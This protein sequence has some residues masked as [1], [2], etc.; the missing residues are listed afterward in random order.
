VPNTSPSM[1]LDP[2]QCDAV[3]CEAV[4]LR[5]YNTFAP[6]LPRWRF[7]LPVGWSIGGHVLTII[8]HY[9]TAIED[10]NAVQANGSL[11]VLDGVFTLDAQYGY[12]VKDWVGKELTLRIGVYNMFDTLPQQ[13]YDLNGFESMLYDPRGAMFYAKASATF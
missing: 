12:T 10:D 8:G 1:T 5:N 7:N 2:P 6:P 3:E 9:M 13:T 11:G 4:G